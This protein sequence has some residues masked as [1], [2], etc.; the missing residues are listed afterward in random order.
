M[1]AGAGRLGGIARRGASNLAV[2]VDGNRRNAGTDSIRRGAE[3]HLAAL[4]AL[5]A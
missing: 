3:N 5:E 4:D 1:D 2:I